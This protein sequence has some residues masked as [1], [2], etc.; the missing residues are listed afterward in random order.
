MSTVTA[1][2]LMTAEEFLA[3]PPNDMDRWLIEGRLREKPMTY[4]NRFHSWLTSRISQLLGNW[5]DQQPQ[6][7]G[8]VFD[9]EAGCRLAGDPDSVV[10]VDVV[11]ISAELAAQESTST[12]IDGVPTLV[13]E[14]LSPSDTQEEI[15]EKIAVYLKAGVPLIWIVNPYDNTVRV[16]Q[17]DQE[18]ELF[19]VHQ[20]LSAEPHLP[21]FRVKVE[22]IFSR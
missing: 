17:P 16:Y 15:H 22:R 13:V 1:P 11:Y 4:R 6:P 14:V 19:N 7:R 18:P 20:D 8:E 10:G 3:L 2:P 12:I 21:G 5:L 9:G